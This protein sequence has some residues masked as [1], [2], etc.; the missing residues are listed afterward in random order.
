MITLGGLFVVNSLQTYQSLKILDTNASRSGNTNEILQLAGDTYFAIQSAELYLRDYMLNG[1]EEEL[2][3]YIS[4]VSNV[5]ALITQLQQ[6]ST[7]LPVQRSRFE[8]LLEMISSHDRALSEALARHRESI[9]LES[10][11]STTTGDL[12]LHE[13]ESDKQK[14]ESLADIMTASRQGLTVLS[15]MINAIEKE[16]LSHIQDILD[17]SA[18]RRKHVSQAVL[19]ANC[20]GLGF[21]LIIAMLTS[22]T[23]RQQVEYAEH[24]E[25][26]V[27]ERTQELELFSQE[28]S[29]SNREL[30]N[31]A[32]VASHDLQEPLRK[33][34][35]FGD[36]L[37]DGYS[38]SLGEGKD[39]VDR[40]QSA[41]KRMSKLIEDLLAFSRITTHRKPFE[42]VDLNEAVSITLDDL[43]FKIE[44]TGAEIICDQLPTIT[45]DPTQM[46]QLFLNLI[47]NAIKFVAPGVKP[48][49]HIK[50]E[51]IPQSETSEQSSA[52][53]LQ[54]Q[55]R[56]TDQPFVRI[57]I[58]DNGIG[59]DEQFLNKI[60]S[61]FQRLHHRDEYEGTGIGLAICRRI[62]ERHGGSIM[63]SSQ[64][65]AGATFIVELPLKLEDTI[66]LSQA[67]RGMQMVGV[68]TSGQLTRQE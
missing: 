20:L 14:A 8:Q 2:E 50:A 52:L 43:Q 45:A 62:A 68:E 48:I 16:E 26:K 60:F 27:R 44:E 13:A 3:S 24:L 56:D 5:K 36:R 33:I 15:E 18:Q 64:S 47:G 12:I 66:E 29:R 1:E 10:R 46:C 11:P 19:L 55:D 17:E 58:Q 38:E 34:R 25:T 4:S 21:L 41:A 28:L 30:E 31:F 65:G 9:A 59:F 61:A 49:I 37:K 42:S 67:D 35:T 6:K 7:E 53:L 40:M 63:A 39:Y 22:R 32:F 54:D 23:S 51:E 57:T